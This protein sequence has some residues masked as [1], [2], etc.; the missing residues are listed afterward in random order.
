MNNL[1]EQIYKLG[2]I[3]VIKIDDV[4]KAVPLAKSLIDGNLSCPIRL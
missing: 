3:P 4:E 2:I 1:L